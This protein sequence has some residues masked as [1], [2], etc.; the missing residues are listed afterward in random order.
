METCEGCGEDRPDGAW[1]QNSHAE[2]T[3]ICRQCH[4]RAADYESGTGVGFGP[5]PLSGK[6]NMVKVIFISYA[7]QGLT[8]DA[9]VE[10]STDTQHGDCVYALPGLVRWVVNVAQTPIAF[11]GPDWITELWFKDLGAAAE[12][13]KSPEMSACLTDGER[14]SDLSRCEGP[15][16]T[17]DHNIAR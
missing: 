16:I 2:H 7:Q 5:P 4:D 6:C 10:M 13:L 12:C 8:R 15:V 14:F 11:G 3:W 9:A 17:A 1:A